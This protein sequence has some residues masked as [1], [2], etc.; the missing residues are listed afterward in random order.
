MNYYKSRTPKDF[1]FKNKN[2]AK[3]LGKIAFNL[4]MI[5]CLSYFLCHL[6]AYKLNLFNHNDEVLCG[7]IFE[8]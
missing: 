4:F 5:L 3:K 1:G 2:K 6:V 7:H 8:R